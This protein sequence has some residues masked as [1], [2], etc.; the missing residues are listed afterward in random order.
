MCV[1]EMYKTGRARA[2]Y[3]GTE[4]PLAR[5]AAD[6]TEDPY[7]GSYSKTSIHRTMIKDK[8]KVM[9]HP[10]RLSNLKRANSRGGSLHR[11]TEGPVPKQE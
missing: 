9:M 2:R 4:I 1:V 6:F 11:R 7:F 8:M 3:L 5:T 10:A